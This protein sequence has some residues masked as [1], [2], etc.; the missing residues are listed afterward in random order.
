MRTKAVRTADDPRAVLTTALQTSLIGEG[1]ATGLLVL[2]PSPTP[3]GLRAHDAR[4]LCEHETDDG[5]FHPLP[6][7][8]AP[9]PPTAPK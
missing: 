2:R 4:R 3:G 7:V 9:P 5:G 6:Q 1:P 8:L